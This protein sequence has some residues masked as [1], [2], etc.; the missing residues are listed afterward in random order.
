MRGSE[1]TG[2]SASYILHILYIKAEI[3][4]KIPRTK[5]LLEQIAKDNKKELPLPK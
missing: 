5:A 2:F 1:H 3:S 4:M